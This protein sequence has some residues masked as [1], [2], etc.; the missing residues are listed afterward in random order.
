MQQPHVPALSTS[1]VTITTLYRV[2]TTI[3]D[4]LLSQESLTFRLGAKVTTPVG[5]MVIEI[6]EELV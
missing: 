5:I 2:T 6:A 4:K 1:Y 3:N